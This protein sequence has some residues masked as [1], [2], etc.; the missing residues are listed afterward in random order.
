MQKFYSR[1]LGERDYSLFEAVHVGL[2]LP[3]MYSPLP[4]VSLSTLGGRAWK[5]GKHLEACGP[6]DAVEWKSRLDR[7]DERLQLVRKGHRGQS[8]AGVAARAAAEVSVRD[9]SLYEFYDKWKVDRGRVLAVKKAVALMVTPSYSADCASVVDKRHEGFARMCVVAFWRHMATARRYAMIEAAGLQADVRRWGGSVFEDPA[10]HAGAGAS[11]LDRFLGYRDLVMA[12]EGR[13]TC[14]VTWCLVDGVRRAKMDS[15]CCV[16][17]GWPYA[18]MEML[19]DPLLSTWVPGWIVEQYRRWNEGFEGFV[20]EVLAEDGA[21]VLSNRLVLR[22]VMVKLRQAA[23]KR[24]RREERQGVEDGAGRF[25][26]W[27]GEFRG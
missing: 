19:V 17:Y 2:G 21:Q 9:V 24:A 25:G 8:A 6:D 3:L 18:L 1:M 22:G 11:E 10:V 23:K 27:V 4:V 13:R 16:K 26:R 15:K 7:F 14:E 5:S 20:R 12:F